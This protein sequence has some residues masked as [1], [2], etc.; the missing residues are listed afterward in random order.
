MAKYIFVVVGVGGTG[1]LLA[2][3]LPKLLIGTNHEMILIDGDRVEEK[4]MKRQSYQLHD[5][6]ENKAIALSAKINSFYETTCRAH[7]KYLTKDEILMLCFGNIE[8]KDIIN[9]YKV[10]VIIGCVDNDK[11]RVILEKTF[12]S[13]NDCVYIDSANSEFEGNVYIASRSKGKQKG[14]C[15]SEIYELSMDVHPAEK[16]CQELAQENIQ[17]L[18]TNVKMATVVLEHCNMLLKNDLKE[19]VTLVRGLE[20]VHI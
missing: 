17:F 1:S 20:T 13:V 14:K 18:V 9:D 7:D 2:R 16:S 19:G 6:G 15:R 12:Q 5:I 10:P 3:D 8:N 4:N 11:T